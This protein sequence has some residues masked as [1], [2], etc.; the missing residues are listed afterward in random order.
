[1]RLSS[2]P[3]NRQSR[4]HT[5][6]LSIASLAAIIMS[7]TIIMNPTVHAFFSSSGGCKRTLSSIRHPCETFISSI[8]TIHSYHVNSSKNLLMGCS[9]QN[10]QN[11]KYHDRYRVQ[12]VT[13]QRQI[14]FSSINDESSKPDSSTNSN[15]YYLE[16]FVPTPEDMEDIG[17]LL[18]VGSKGG[19]VILLDGDLGAGKT[20]FSRGFIRGRT[21]VEDER[22]TSPTY[23][24]SNSYVIDEDIKIYHMDLYRLSG[25]EEDLI[26][27]NLDNV[28]TKDISLIEWPSRLGNKKPSVRLDVTLTINDSTNDNEDDGIESADMDSQCRRMKLEPYGERWI[29]HLQF[30]VSEGYFEDLIVED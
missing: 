27:L 17:G 14:L 19:D 20:C 3:I 21:G 22:V 1:M 16:L 12:R 5:L 8:R 4:G 29:E 24:L 26:P 9:W 25:T 2:S 6:S 15:N 18:S 7:A 23:L 13:H 30:L 28:F 11:K 10:Y